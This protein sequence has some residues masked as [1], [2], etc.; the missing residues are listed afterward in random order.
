MA[1]VYHPHATDQWWNRRWP[2]RIFLLRELSAV[3]IAIYMVVFLLLVSRVRSDDADF[4]DV[5]KNPLMIALHVLVLAFALLHTVTWF[6]AVPKAM[7]LK[8]GDMRVPGTTMI[9]GVYGAWAVASIVV[10]IIFL[11]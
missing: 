4:L 6:Q 5:L 10:L 1:K 2:Y 8:R 11:A 7:V 9:A 3:F